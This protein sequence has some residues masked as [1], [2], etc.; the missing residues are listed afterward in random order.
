MLLAAALV[1][2]LVVP[3]LA[4]AAK[5]VKKPPGTGNLTIGASSNPVKYGFSVTIS[6]TLRGSDNAAKK[7][8]LQHDPYPYGTTY[9]T[10][11]TTTTDAKGNYSF[12][13]K[14]VK[15]TNFRTVAKTNPQALSDN[16]QVGVKLRVTRTVDDFTPDR[17]Q[18]VTFSGTVVPSHDGRTVYIQ[19]RRKDGTWHNVAT[20]TLTDAGA[21]KPTTSNYSRDLRIYRD[22][23]FRMRVRSHGD[24][25]GNKS[26]RIR[27]DVP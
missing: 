4:T 25:V 20:T 6:G 14:P 9:D 3:L 8:E 1:A 13:V 7:I 26:R 22:G 17:G 16:L 15:N 11:A 24:H 23:L 19:R 2:M 18:P 27:L 5:P 12:T 10:L 21:D